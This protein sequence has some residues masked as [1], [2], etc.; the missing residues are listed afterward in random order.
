M[1][2]LKIAFSNIR[3]RKS[4]AITLFVITV[5]SALV[6]SISLSIIFNIGSFYDNKRK[7][8]NTPDFSIVILGDQWQDSMIDY[9]KNYDGVTETDITQSYMGEIKYESGKLEGKS[10]AAFNLDEE[11]HKFNTFNIIDKLAE[12][13]DSSVILP[14]AYKFNGIKAGDKFIVKSGITVY[15]FIVYGFSEDAELGSAMTSVNVFH[16]SQS[17]FIAISNDMNLVPNKYLSLKFNKLS[18]SYD[19]QTDFLRDYSLTS[20]GAISVT[21]EMT[22]TSATMFPLIMALVLT[23]VAAVI[24]TIAF[25]VVRFSI[26]NSIEED[27]KTLGAL[28]SIGFT[29]VQIIISTLFQF[30][31][32]AL[33]GGVIGVLLGALAMGYVG[34][35]ISS[36]SGL[37]WNNTAFF[38]PAFLAVLLIC[39]LTALITL[40]ISRKSKKITP[41]NALRQGSGNHTFIKN[42]APLDKTKLPLNLNV[43]AKNFAHSIKNNIV[44]FC[45]VFLFAMLTVLSSTLYHNFVVDLSAF[46]KMVGLETAE[47]QISAINEQFV[48]DKFN[49][50]KDKENVEKTLDFDIFSVTSNNKLVRFYVWEDLTKR[51]VSTVIEGRYPKND[52]EITLTSGMS[53]ILDKIIGDV[54]TVEYDGKTESYLVTGIVQGSGDT[55][56]YCDMTLQGF[57]KL[58][59]NIVLKNMY[60]YLS[61]S[62]SE[63]IED[64]RNPLIAEYGRE[65]NV[66]NYAEVTD[67]MFA[68]IEGPVAIASYLIAVI[69][70]F[71][72][73][74]TFFLMI[75]TI[76]RR[77][78]R[79]Y[80]IMKAVGFTSGQLIAQM[81]ISFLPII[82]AGVCF[83]A[84]IGFLVT[85][86]IL[87]VMFSGAGIAKAMFAIPT[88]LTVIAE[89]LL[90]GVCVLTVYL[91]S[92]KTKNISPQK[93]IAE[94]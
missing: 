23:L 89:I 82:F 81:L 77:R 78:K 46:K 13:P 2:L 69:T 38:V 6:L 85:N 41:I 29:S 90:A 84:L 21:Y 79:D 45:V 86:P 35:I 49:E 42:R 67:E 27:I 33:S 15:D 80:G 34:E 71:V 53:K 8:L 65:M 75:N 12:K 17:E 43:A 40:L 59:D 83:G 55:A 18:R 11:Q 57:S 39:S 91:V 9:V 24:M 72:V 19:F 20:S 5:V 37:L 66:L 1:K 61:S 26:V 76:I 16:V 10:Q 51:E 50:I 94:V 87:S 62:D 92:L 74:F 31:F 44:T 25:I 52:N 68:S 32:I 14:L 22:K 36:T 28:K 3:K 7:E 73:C 64:F 58:K 47:I 4:S 56:V 63:F 93:L 30:L 70:I 54:V 88:V 60:I 48:L